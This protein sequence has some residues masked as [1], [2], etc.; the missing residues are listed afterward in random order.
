[1]TSPL[2]W[3]F[4]STGGRNG[5]GWVQNRVDPDDLSAATSAVHNA[6]LLCFAFTADL[7]QQKFKRTFQRSVPCAGENR[8]VNP[9]IFPLRKVGLWRPEPLSDAKVEKRRG[10]CLNGFRAFITRS[11]S[12]AGSSCYRNSSYSKLKYKRTCGYKETPTCRVESHSCLMCRSTLPK[13]QTRFQRSAHMR[14]G[15][16]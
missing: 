10:L 1:M 16:I 8:L 4:K 15:E 6:I 7:N 3:G 5:L 2:G 11:S 14:G 13:L 9:E 12:H